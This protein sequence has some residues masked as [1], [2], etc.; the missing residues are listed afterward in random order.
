MQPGGQGGRKGARGRA[1]REPGKG[2]HVRRARCLAASLLAHLRTQVRTRGPG[3][4]GQALAIVAMLQKDQRGAHGRCSLPHDARV[5]DVELNVIFISEVE[6]HRRLGPLCALEAH[7]VAA[8]PS[9]GGWAGTT[10]QS[11]RIHNLPPRVESVIM[12]CSRLIK[13]ET[14]AAMSHA[15]PTERAA[16]GTQQTCRG[17]G[18]STRRSSRALERTAAYRSGRGSCS[19]TPAART[20]PPCNSAWPGDGRAL[21][22]RVDRGRGRPRPAAGPSPSSGAASR[23]HRTSRS[24]P[25]GPRPQ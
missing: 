24:P 16:L 10:S 23:R 14:A 12:M 5:V 21:Q 22:E 18:P 7:K 20:K 19:A 17:V 1:E 15:R 2:S 9:A 8:M 11:Y 3:R 6:E 13:G 25:P 4:E